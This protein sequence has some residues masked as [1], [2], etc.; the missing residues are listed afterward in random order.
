MVASA[1]EDEAMDWAKAPQ[2]REQL[3]MFPTRLDEAIGPDHVV[4]LCD[5]ILARLNWSGFEAEYDRTRGGFRRR[6][7]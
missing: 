3:V 7:T 4:R 2:K 1:A 6:S 5:E